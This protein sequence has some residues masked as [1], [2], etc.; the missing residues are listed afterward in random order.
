MLDASWLRTWFERHGDERPRVFGTFGLPETTVLA[1][2][3]RIS[4]ADVEAGIASVIGVPIDDLDVYVLDRYQ[5][6]APVGITGEMYIGGP[7]IARGYLDRPDLTRERF[8]NDPVN[9][10][11]SRL[12]RSGCCGRWLPNGDLEFRGRLDQQIEIPGRVEMQALAAPSL[13]ARTRGHVAPRNDIELALAMIWASVLGCEV[14]GV[15][16]NFF[17][18]GGDSMSTI[19]VIARSRQLG[20]HV[21]TRDVFT[22]PTIAALGA[23]I[24]SRSEPPQ[25]PVGGP[26]AVT[27]TP[28]IRRF[29]EQPLS[30]RNHWNEA[31]L[32]SVPSSLD[33]SALDVALTAVVDRHDVFRLRLREDAAGWHAGYVPP[34]PRA[35]V[36]RVD[37][38]D[39]PAEMISTAI[40]STAASVQAGLDISDGP[41]LRA[42]HFACAA[43]QPGRLLIVMHHVVADAGVWPA[44]LEDLEIAYAAARAGREPVLPG[45]TTS[46]S[47]WGERLAGYASTGAL[48][49]LACWGADIDPASA[50]LPHDRDGDPELNTEASTG[51]VAVS[52]TAAETATLLDSA[53]AACSAEVGDLILASLAQ[54]LVRWTGRDDV[55]VDVE[56]HRRPTLFDDVDLSRTIGCFATVVPVKL[57]IGNRALGDLVQRTTETLRRVHH[58][59]LSFGALRYLSQDGKVRKSLETV[60]QPQLR[61][62]YVAESDAIPPGSSLFSV[63]AESSGPCRGGDNRRSHLL[64]V[65]AFIKDGRLKLQWTY[66]NQFHDAATISGVASRCIESLRDLVVFGADR[67]AIDPRPSGFSLARLSAS[68]I[69][70]L[71]GRFPLLSDIYPLTP[72]QQL[73][74]TMDA[75]EPSSGLEQWEFL[76][77]GPV[78]AERLR[79]AWREVTARHAILRTVFAQVGAATPHQVVLEHVELPWHEEDWREQTPERQDELL[80]R[81]LSDDRRRSFDL[82]TPPLLRVALFRIGDTTHRLILST[83]QLLVD[84]CSLPQIITDLS[85]HYASGSVSLKPACGYRE[86]VKWLQQDDEVSEV[87]WRRFLNGVK[88]ATPAPSVASVSGHVGE[89]AGEVVRSLTRG[90]TQALGA[91]ARR[92]QVSVNALVSAAW[93]VVLA[94]RSGRSDVVFGASLAHHPNDI[95]GIETMIGPRVNNLPIRVRV[96]ANEE[97]APWLGDLQRSVGE[98]ARHQTTPLARIQK[99]SDIPAWSR[100]FDSLLVIQDDLKSSEI[101]GV[102]LRLL[103]WVGSSGCPATVMVRLSEQLEIRIIGAG[104]SFGTASAA[105]AADDLVTVLHRLTEPN[106]GTVGQLLACLPSAFAGSARRGSPEPRRRRGPRLAAR[107]DM[108]KALVRIWRELFGEDIGTDENYFELGAHSLM[109]VRAHE[110]IGSTIDPVLPIHALLQFP[111]IRA[112]AAHLQSRSAPVRRADKIRSYR[113]N[114]GWGADRGEEAGTKDRRA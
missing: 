63:A 2:H 16:D 57:E 59:G 39:Y 31:I 10:T 68:E 73:L 90:R 109:M 80:C 45:R 96:D 4:E 53:T 100:M 8:V 23:A 60:P 43:G 24:A 62:E 89:S 19:Q 92:R 7:G 108:E 29:L 27:L 106:S 91:M 97:V 74:F 107:T 77:E 69:D 47:T 95:P 32:L 67:A 5:Q 13:P 15:E 21:T 12:Y 50:S 70:R 18:L 82:A 9:G 79:S 98:V 61:F 48:E 46:F 22:F 14:M 72:M 33:V 40:E 34:H 30:N 49:G 85:A 102:Q 87:F 41:I 17:E 105:A 101:D 65:V 52:L 99:C 20:L 113:Q 104:E 28:A 94:H 26:S 36:E 64:E 3:R 71:G 78:D 25:I 37:L 35:C 114:L 81:F 88:E 44:F 6:L 56:D 55:L 66:S 103:R 58:R 54:V 110:R 111:N 1:T 76:L 93:G 84:G 38:R 83:H 75:V 86:Y 11:E 112:L 42:V 51:T